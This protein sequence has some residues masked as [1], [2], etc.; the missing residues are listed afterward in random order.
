MKALTLVKS[1]ICCVLFAAT[2]P[3]TAQ[4]LSESVQFYFSDAGGSDE[5]VFTDVVTSA[6]WTKE[7]DIHVKN[8]W[9]SPI[10]FVAAQ[11]VVGYGQCLGPGPAATL[12][13]FTDLVSIRFPD[14]ASLPIS[15]NPNITR[16]ATWN[17]ESPTTPPF[18]G[19]AS[20][21]GSGEAR[22]YGLIVPMDNRQRQIQAPPVGDTIFLARI[23]FKN[24]FLFQLGGETLLSLSAGSGT[25]NTSTCLYDTRSQIPRVFRTANWEQS[26]T[27]RLMPVPEPS[28]LCLV[29]SGVLVLYRNRKMARQ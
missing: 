10:E 15:Q 5:R 27:L 19:G 9:H 18:L 21:P 12:I 3:S 20:G 14:Q 17:V 8:V 2:L 25:I 23:S 7:Y 1:F 13:P 24:R 11:L 6:D 29:G 26:S 28:T 16:I 22:P 4:P